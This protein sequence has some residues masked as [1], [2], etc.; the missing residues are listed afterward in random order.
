MFLRELQPVFKGQT[1]CLVM[2]LSAAGRRNAVWQTVCGSQCTRAP[3]SFGGPCAH[4]WSRVGPKARALC[5]ALR[6]KRCNCFNLVHFCPPR[7][8]WEPAIFW[9]V[10]Q[11]RLIKSYARKY[12]AF[13]QHLHVIMCLPL[14]VAMIHFKVSKFALENTW[15]RFEKQSDSSCFCENCNVFS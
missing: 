10:W 2:L 1:R 14:C 3:M 8:H 9:D 15:K 6:G 7:G 13:L 12:S 11:Q 5:K 4:H